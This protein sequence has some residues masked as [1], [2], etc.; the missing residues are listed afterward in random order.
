[1]C[2][3]VDFFCRQSLQIVIPCIYKGK[4]YDMKKYFNL[5]AVFFL[6]TF[7]IAGCSGS[8]SSTTTV[9]Q[10][11]SPVIRS[12][13]VQGLPAAPGSLITT[14]VIAQSAQNL[15]LTYTWT[16]TSPWIVSPSSVNSQTATITAPSGYAI[17]GTATVEVSDTYGRY[18]LNTIPLSTVGDIAPVINSITA[19]PNPASRSGTIIA[20]V[21]AFDV[22]GNKFTESW[23]AT[24]GWEVTGYGTTATV[25][26]PNTYST[27]GYLTVTVSDNSGASAASTIALGT[28]PDSPPV[29]T[30]FSASPNPAAQGGSMSLSVSAISPD[31][32]QLYYT[33]QAAN[34]W[35]IATGQG[36]SGIT[37]TAPDQYGVS[38]TFTVTVCDRYG[39]TV[40]LPIPVS[41]VGNSAPVITGFSASPNPVT[42]GGLM[43][44]A[45]TASDPDGDMLSYTWQV[46][47]GW[48]IA[49]GQGT[50]AVTVTAPTQYG[51]SGTVTV[52][53]DD[54]HGDAVNW[55]LPVSTYLEFLPSITVSPQPVITST[56]LTCNGYYPLDNDLTFNWTVGGLPLTTGNP[57][58]WYSPGLPGYYI[59]GVT[60]E[61]GKAGI[62]ISTTPIQVNS[63]SPWPMFHGNIQST[64]QSPID[65]SSI[66]NTT[67][68]TTSTITTG[69]VMDKVSSPVIGADGTIYVGN[70][71]QFGTMDFTDTGFLYA[72]RPTNGTVKW[73]YPTGPVDSPPV[74]GADGTIYVGSLV[75]PTFGGTW[76]TYTYALYPTGGLKWS[77]TSTMGTL[78]NSP[79]IGADG[80]VYMGI[81]GS[82]YALNP[83]DGSVKWS[84]SINSS[85]SN[86]PPAI[87]ADGTIYV[88]GGAGANARLDALNP[89]DGSVKWYC[90]IASPVLGTPAIGADG[91]IYVVDSAN[92]VYAI[93]PTD[94]S[95]KWGKYNLQY[96]STSPAIGSNGLIYVGGLNYMNALS[97]TDGSVQWQF[98]LGAGAGCSADASPAIGAD[99]TIY[100]GTNGNYGIPNIFALTSTGGLKWSYTTGNIVRSDPAIGADG[101]VYIGSFDGYLYAFH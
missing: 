37:V 46:S 13:S 93:N 16:A 44:I 64:G 68:W 72:L 101:T 39:G 88:N 71:E 75:Q 97:I 70:D 41:T 23:A 47:N 35:T 38:G 7:L 60:V 33:W 95:L 10:G 65:T 73:V 66:T 27:G 22:Q 58:V 28:Q 84:Q 48:L 9:V 100:F 89:T 6:I 87:G 77:I 8:G 5:L 21:T 83:T 57:A 34:G 24:T 92:N 4:E 82:L 90:P 42:P 17:T 56:T 11:S 12:L 81:N 1:M 31:G 62:A 2:R 49:T 36:T 32:N 29:I 59:V 25:I 3:F 20:Q 69:T 19:S 78:T 67:T 18:A 15:A 50:S 94:G 53:V 86:Y 61:N 91:T 26:A 96:A 85:G 52:T 54:G 55:A 79:A 99:G 63:L 98:N 51:V 30:G 40:S 14:T 74:V 80:T 45:V 76:T 43:A